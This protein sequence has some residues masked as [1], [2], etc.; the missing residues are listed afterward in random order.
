MLQ[1]GGVGG[2]PLEH[3]A[4]PIP[5]YPAA[6]KTVRRKRGVLCPALPPFDGRILWNRSVNMP[7]EP[8]SLTP[9]CDE[10]YRSLVMA[11]VIHRRPTAAGCTRICAILSI[12]ACWKHGS[13]LMEKR[14]SRQNA[15]L[16][17]IVLERQSPVPLYHQ[18][19]EQLRLAMVEGNLRP[20]SYL[21]ASRAFARDLGVSR[22]TCARAYD[23]LVADGFLESIRGSGTR[24][25]PSQAPLG[26]ETAQE[27]RALFRTLRAHEEF[28]PQ[29]LDEYIGEPAALA[30]QPGI[31]ALDA[32]PRLKW[33][34]LLRQHALR[35]DQSILDYAHPGGYAPLRQELAKYL[36]MSRGV[37]CRAE[38]V[39]V[40][41][42]TRAAIRAIAS[43]M[44]PRASRIMVED[45][46][47]VVAKRALASLGHDLLLVPVDDSG[48]RIDD[49]IRR[50]IDC[51]GAY[52]TPAHQW[53]TGTTLSDERR[54]T[55]LD[56]AAR[57][58]AWIIEDD[59]D[60]EF[61]LDGPPLPTLHSRGPGQVLYVG[62]FSKVLVP[63]IRTAYFVVP[64]DLVERFETEVFRQ[65]VEP[66]LHIQAA[67][68]DLI[69]DG[70]F[71]S[72]I[73]RMRKRYRS[74]R[75]RLIEALRRH[76]GD[77]LRIE[78]PAGGLQIIAHLPAGVSAIEAAR[79]AAAAG[80]VARPMGVYCYAGGAPE[81]L[82]L[83]F[84]A[85]PAEDIDHMIMRLREAVR[86]CL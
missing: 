23:Q 3:P 64:A 61:R 28:R 58:K 10:G 63:A 27:T 34:R 46:G 11:F 47:Y 38:Q 83:G 78:C 51:A 48:A 30:F 53:P 68:A 75:A 1:S 20:G 8:I 80:L 65:G 44:W 67:L 17:W 13:T 84:A 9:F 86:P 21:P 69:R 60:S 2:L 31:P 57:S 37:V 85:V 42:S 36:T 79:L 52:L 55:L 16:N 71:A 74:S 4:V 29:D 45:P 25:A 59:Y 7:G 72:H 19:V 18:I 77:L 26:S 73:T 50:R 62:T 43:I 35:G 82:H 22:N 6:R 66:A 5:E 56:W 76:F 40:V 41:T 32:F 81:A 39:I 49:L 15:L 33:S 70:T 54:A 24:V 12:K 14:S